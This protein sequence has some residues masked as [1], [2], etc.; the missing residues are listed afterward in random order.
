MAYQLSTLVSRVQTKLDDSSFDTAT[1]IQFINDAQNELFNNSKLRFTETS[2][3]YTLAQ[4]VAEI[5]NGSGLPTNFHMPIDLRISSP[6]N[7]AGKLT[8]LPHD[9]FFELYPDET[10]D[11]NGIPSE[12]TEYG[13]SIYVSPKP[14]SG[15]II[16]TLR[17]VKKPTELSADADVPTLPSEWSELLVLMAYCRC[18][19]FND[20]EDKAAYVRA[21]QV[22]PML[23]D[24]KRRHGLRRIDGPIRMVD[25]RNGRS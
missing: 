9:V 8:Y 25:R 11:P 7:M 2:T 22:E 14:N 16:V 20:E 15:S 18:L 10:D 6:Y 12:W 13:G 1:I 4:G 23:F 19:D 3:T 5:T 17:Y 24:L 21:N